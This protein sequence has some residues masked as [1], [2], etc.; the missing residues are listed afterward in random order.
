MLRSCFAA[1]LAWS[2][3][4][5]L[6]SSLL[7]HSAVGQESG[8]EAALAAYADA[9]N[10]QTNGAFELAVEAWER[11]LERYPDHAMA[12]KAAHY[13]GVSHMQREDP[14]YLAAARA[15]AQALQD[16]ES[17]LREESFANRGWCLYASAE[18]APPGETDREEGTQGDQRAAKRERLREAI[19]TFEQLHEEKPETG[20]L[21]RAY[22]YSGEAA[23]ALGEPEQAVGFYDQLLAMPAAKESPLHCETLYGRGVAMEDLDRQE[24]ALD[25]YG[26]LLDRCEDDSLLTDVQL[27]TGDLLIRLQRPGEAIELFSAAEQSAESAEDRA[28]AIFREAYASV[29]SDRPAEAAKK[30]EQLLAE[31]PDS[32]YASEAMLASA[33]STYRSGDREAAAVRFEK[34]LER[35]DPAAATEAAHWLARIRLD[36]GKVGLARK[37]AEQQLNAGAAGEFAL[38]LKLDLAEALS[39]DPE[40]VAESLERFE[41]AYRDAPDDPLAPRALYNAAF[42][43]LQTNENDRAIE[44]ADEFLKRFSGDELTPDVK[45]IAAEGRLGI[46]RHEEAATMYAELLQETD[47]SDRLQRPSWILRA[48]IANNAAERY[49]ETVELLRREMESQN[50]TQPEDRAHAHFLLGQAHRRAGHHA[51]AAEAFQASAEAAED[52]SAAPQAT[53]LAGRSL[54]ADGQRDAAVAQ[55][56][57]VQQQ[58]PET[59]AA[60]RARY[61][62][63]QLAGREGDFASAIATYDEILASG[64]DPSLRPHALYG[65]G[66]SQMRQGD[67]AG[68]IES[69]D[70]TLE[71]AAA[72]HPIRDDALLSR[73]ISRRNEGDVA[74]AREDLEAFLE[75]QPQGEALGNALYELALA[76]QQAR[77]PEAAASHLRRLREQVPDYPDMDQVRYELA[78]SLREAGDE[79]GAADEFAALVEHH[80]ENPLVAEAAYFL[81]Q[82]LYAEQAWEEAAARFETAAAS[83]E[84]PEL[85]E[86]S[87]YRLGWARF[88]L[89]EFETSEEVFRRQ[90]EQFPDGDLHL[91]AWMMIGESEFKRERFAAALDAYRECRDLLRDAGDS[92]ETLRDDAERRVRELI[93]LHG[94]QCASQL[95]EF[96]QAIQWYDELRKRFPA[97]AYLPQ[98]FYETG[99]AYQQLGDDER[100]LQFYGEVANN[101]RTEIAAR[102]RFM[103]GE[104]RFGNERYDEAIPEFQR[105]MFGF[106]AEQASGEIKNWQA[107][108]GFEAGRCAEALMQNAKSD[109]A[110][111][112]SHELV[113]TFYQ[114][115]V[116]KHPQHELAGEARERIEGLDKP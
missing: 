6:S 89:G 8:E 76:E 109:A 52:W 104:I 73:G 108:S 70:Q 19:R 14:D 83:G 23:F 46:G 49:D 10:F 78:W 74:G 97:T 102:A 68:A 71:E 87:L 115:V 57:S 11:F 84:D 88:K 2:L 35:S 61:E 93:L 98:V 99:Y 53:L 17:E 34:V 79:Q 51:E 101:Y 30:Y 103:M 77:S 65:K 67:H 48:A 39:R 72:D 105:V 27:R 24:E 15:F 112:R 42:S 41:Q 5:C 60:D 81:G 1:W 12:S 69:L 116:D 64:N 110:K 21:D 36:Q 54:L 94:G 50:L 9:A 44:W 82:R 28:Y 18:L 113:Q 33:Q 80:P 37:V 43:A 32:R 56:E 4:F 90:A 58:S 85:T 91:D 13:L 92:A 86:K 96:E 22:F 106:G 75:G 20:F 29:R 111:R 16:K 114:Y 40:T 55:W 59:G 95:D 3:A 31:Y 100:A 26:Q 45:Y 66:W 38:A 7:S 63:A 107:K 25:A 47:G 62:L